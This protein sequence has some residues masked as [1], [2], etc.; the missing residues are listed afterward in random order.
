MWNEFNVTNTFTLETSMYG[1]RQKDKEDNQII[2]NIHQL[3]I[4]DFDSIAISLLSTIKNYFVLETQLEK[5]YNKNGGWLKK[6]KLNQVVGESARQ[7]QENQFKSSKR[8]T[9]ISRRSQS[10]A[11]LM[12]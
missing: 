1:K 12:T 10:N 7:K 4:P 2:E 9:S 8:N 6:Q 11:N 5:E 3:T